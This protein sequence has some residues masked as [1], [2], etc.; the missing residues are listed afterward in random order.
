MPP[1]LAGALGTNARADRPQ[2]SAR[3][4]N[5]LIEWFQSESKELVAQL[6]VRVCDLLAQV[7]VAL[8]QA[9]EREFDGGGRVGQM[10]ATPSSD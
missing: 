6:G 2:L 10:I 4:E 7:L 3:E 8:G 9:L 1:A 5:V